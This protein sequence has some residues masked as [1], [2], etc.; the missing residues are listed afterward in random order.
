LRE[1]QGRQL[2]NLSGSQEE[3]DEKERKK[4]AM[5]LRKQPGSGMEAHKPA[6]WQT[7]S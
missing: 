7:S 3:D 6:T 5:P 1:K 2:V 4:K